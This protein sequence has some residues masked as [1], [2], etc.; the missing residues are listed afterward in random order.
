MSNPFQDSFLKAGLTN[1]KKVKQA[2]R[3]KKQ[4]TKKIRRGQSD[5]TTEDQQRAK[6][7]AQAQLERDRE[8]NRAKEEKAQQKAITAQIKQL[9]AS[10][11]IE[12]EGE[13]SVFRFEDDK[14]IKEIDVDTKMQKSLVAGRLCIAKSGSD[15]SIIAKPVADKISQRDP[16]VIVLANSVDAEAAV[17]EDEYKEF[18]IPD[19]LM[20]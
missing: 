20:W 2:Q 6:E 17:E 14:V 12:P 19:D 10:N 1:K 3:D 5:G 7:G 8:L 9:I 16:Q 18:E 15:Y 11:K 13:A 4:V